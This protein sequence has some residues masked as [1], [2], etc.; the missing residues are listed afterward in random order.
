[1]ARF[2]SLLTSLLV[3]LGLILSG[4]SA[5]DDVDLLLR[6]PTPQFDP[7]AIQKA[8][9][10]QGEL[11]KA[12]SWNAG[13]EGRSPITT[14]QWRSFVV[15]GFDFADGQCEEYL[16]ALRRLDIAR[17]RAVQQTNLV[18][19]AVAGIL[20]I[21]SAAAGAI[22]ITAIAFGL[23]AATIENVAGS[24]LFELPP[25]AVRTLVVRSRAAYEENL[26]ADNWRDRPA[27]FRT[28]RGYV[29][30]C[31]PAVIEANAA[32]AIRAAQPEASSGGGALRGTPPR[33]DVPSRA[34]E[35]IVVTAASADLAAGRLGTAGEQNLAPRQVSL[36]QGSLCLPADRRTGAFDQPTRAAIQHYRDALRPGT[37]GG[38]SLNEAQYLLGAG[39]PALGYRNAYE[40]FAYR[41]PAAIVGLQADLAAKAAV[42][43]A[44]LGTAGQFT[45]QTR[46]VIRALQKQN[47][48]PETGEV[49]SPLIDKL[50]P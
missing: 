22:A 21:V 7:A 26:V 14:E 20:G 33:V 4:C 11:L 10:D 12:I 41:T 50:S 42:P 30:L 13:L 9:H 15:A 47:N 19:S 39:C 6:G 16:S 27:A 40:R 38:L 32:S 5:R 29:E 45:E 2:Q 8:S 43:V 36:I 18:G 24:L 46:T 34:R 44:Q 31:L 23:T 25:S 48:L 3:G 28:I 37:I 49:T 17:R 35:P 1:M